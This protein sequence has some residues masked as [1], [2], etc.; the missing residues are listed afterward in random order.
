[1]LT[2]RW[3]AETDYQTVWQAMQRFT[4]QR[5]ATTPDEIWLLQHPPVYTLGQ[6]G[7]PEHMLNAR[8]IPV[9]HT[10]RGG[11]ITYHGPGQLVAYCLV[12]LRRRGLFVR[13]FVTL[14][15]QALLDL[16]TEFALPARRIAGAPGVYVPVACM[17]HAE[18]TPALPPGPSS[19]SASSH[20]VVL[21]ENGAA[22]SFAGWAKVA[23]LGLKV[24]NGC[25]YHGLALNIN[26]DLA[27]FT[28]I[29]PCGYQGMVTTDLQSCGVPL[30]L[31]QA[32]NLLATMLEQAL[33][34]HPHQSG[35]PA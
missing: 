27:P 31:K 35:A 10:D 3:C 6:A 34:K 14:L 23:A 28:A 9:V 16:L 5:D 8:N 15:E 29:D 19:S 26:M 4:R 2:V 21:Q 7:R 13:T 32:G 11:Q 22:L 33:Q 30:S 18:N 20:P 24:S 17:Q 1:M 12:D 25:T